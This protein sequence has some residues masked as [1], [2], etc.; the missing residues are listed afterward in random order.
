MPELG[1]T[2]LRSLSL[3][4]ESLGDTSDLGLH[5]SVDD[6][7]SCSAFSDLRSGKDET[8]SVTAVSVS[9]T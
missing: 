6:D 4:V 3:G 7:D 2:S 8:D 9:Y 5:T 1:K